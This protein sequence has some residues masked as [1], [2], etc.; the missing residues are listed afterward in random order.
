[1]DSPA[2]NFW[3][4][5]DQARRRYEAAGYVVSV[6]ERLESDV[7]PE[8]DTELVAY[9][10][11]RRGEDDAFESRII[12]LAPS[13]RDENSE[14]R[15]AALQ[16]FVDGRPGW[17]LDIVEFERPADARPPSQ[18]LVA[19]WIAEARRLAPLSPA[20]ALA[21][22]RR[23]V[24][25]ALFRLE[26]AR[27]E[28]YRE[29]PDLSNSLISGLE[30][31]GGIS[32]EEAETLR[33]FHTA[34]A[35]GDVS[36]DDGLALEE[37]TEACL[38]IAERCSAEDAEVVAE[39]LAW[40]ERHFC[41]PEQAGVAA[42]SSTG[43][44]VWLDTGPYDARAV[45]RSRFGESEQASLDRAVFLIEQDGLTWARRDSDGLPPTALA[46]DAVVMAT[47]PDAAAGAARFGV[48]IGAAPGYDGLGLVER[49]HILQWASTLPSRAEVVEL[50]RD[51]I[52]ETTPAH[53][54]IRI[55]CPTAEGTGRPDFDVVVE[56]RQ[57][58]TW[59]PAGRSGW[60]VSTS[61]DVARNANTNYRNRSSEA[62][63]DANEITYVYLTPRAWPETKAT[64]STT[65]D[66]AG[67]QPSRQQAKRRWQQ[68][69]SDEGHWRDVRALDV[70][71]L[72][73]WLIQAPATRARFSERL[74]LVPDGFT[75]AR[76][77]W[78]RDLAQTGGRL[79]AEVLLAGRERQFR[80][81]VE[82]CSTGGGTVYVVAES[83]QDALDFILAAGTREAGI[84]DRML[85]V[86]DAAAWRRLKREPGGG[87]ILVAVEPEVADGLE[88][89]QH[90]MVVPLTH[91]IPP[92]TS[93]DEHEALVEIGRI[94]PTAAANALE[95]QGLDRSEAGRFAALGRRSLGALRRMLQLGPTPATPAWL[96]RL[97]NDRDRAAVWA[98]LLAGRWSE[99][100]DSD[101]ALLC[102]LAGT[103]AGYEELLLI[104]R[105]L[106]EGPDPLIAQ[107]G[108]QWELVA[109][110][111]AWRHL[112]S[113]IPESFLD[114]FASAAERALTETEVQRWPDGTPFE[115][116]ERTQTRSSYS[117]DM[118][119][120]IARTAA[121]LGTFG[122]GAP[123]ASRTSA[124]TRAALM[125]R[126][127]LGTDDGG[128]H[129]LDQEAQASDGAPG[130]VECAVRS[131]IQRIVDLAGV[132]PLLAEAAPDAFLEAVADALEQAQSDPDGW[133]ILNEG[134]EG[135]TS[136]AGWY[137]LRR[138][139]ETLAWSPEPS[140]LAFVAES[141][142]KISASGNDDLAD[143]AHNCLVSLFRPW[144]PQTGLT[145][146]R[147][148]EVLTGLCNRVLGDEAFDA[149]TR[150]AALWRC[151][152]ELASLQPGGSPNAG[153]GIRE[154][155]VVVRPAS[156]EDELAATDR[157]ISLLLQMAEFFASSEF[158]CERL[159]DIFCPLD[160]NA[161]LVR[162][163]PG[164]RER[165]LE[166]V[167]DASAHGTLDASLL[168]D[169]MRSFVRLHRHYPDAF[170][171]LGSDELER[172]EHMADRWGDS[173]P[174]TLGAWLFESV[175]PEVD[176][177]GL[178]DEA[179][180]REA[181]VAAQRRAA[182]AQVWADDA[183]EGVLRLAVRVHDNSQ[184]F[185]WRDSASLKPLVP[186]VGRALAE[187]A[188]ARE[189]QWS[190]ANGALLEHLETTLGE[191]LAGAELQ[192]SADVAQSAD[193]DGESAL[194]SD[195]VVPRYLVAHGYFARRVALL[196][197]DGQNLTAWLK[198]IT[199]AHRVDSEAVARLLTTL[200]E[201]PLVWEISASLGAD[202]EAAYWMYFPPLPTGLDSALTV[203]AARRLLGVG[204]PGAAVEL[205]A[206]RHF[207]AGDSEEAA[208]GDN[209]EMV[210]LALRALEVLAD[211]AEPS[212]VVQRLRFW[213]GE[214]LDW[215]SH[216]LPLNELH[217]DDSRRIRLARL[218]L[219]LDD[220]PGSR[221][222][223][224]L[225]HAW[226]E[227]DP[228][229]FVEMIARM[230]APADE[231]MPSGPDE[232]AEADTAGALAAVAASKA[233]TVLHH[234][235]RIPGLRDDGTVDSGVMQDW[236]TQALE[237][238]AKQELLPLGSGYI[239]E[240][241][242][243][244]PAASSDE[245]GIVPPPAVRDVLEAL[246]S[247]GIEPRTSDIEHGLARGISN[248]RGVHSRG[249]MDGGKDERELADR[250]REQ[251]DIVGD[252]WP[253]TA[254][255]LRLVADSYDSHG[256]MHD[257]QSE[258]FARGT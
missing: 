234:W 39:M 147:R 192:T 160:G 236:I 116:H 200:R 76:L 100:R 246:R 94:D 106:S 96:G 149:S 7:G 11:A 189:L 237:E 180:A 164:A 169:R 225:S 74:G 114:R 101:Q 136:D 63:S 176:V 22:A 103:A 255:V 89:S 226:L 258:R 146:D 56:T 138:A 6:S 228:C 139:L 99:Q 93:S 230:Y 214:L 44:Y 220:V 206:Y 191:W 227:H 229:F 92:N 184:D 49:H 78:E 253:R 145:T 247:S 157:V 75:S 34:L 83:T 213:V 4:A 21:L 201:F 198:G 14:A 178:R 133:R 193:P 50:V 77:R 113:E 17:H 188:L 82:R 154:W 173:D 124:E 129:E 232:G 52:V 10:V 37:L 240:M 109:P 249:L 172:I 19:E 250:Y 88:P 9:F 41:T 119:H 46:A 183:L 150:R 36:R 97:P 24:A 102:E 207:E 51:L 174:A 85:L 144:L 127:L 90:C 167:G 33:Y 104:L 71:D 162:L 152:L 248:L 1:M 175:W 219:V 148:N 73:N 81:L 233:W 204:R 117:R 171:S 166:I 141:L 68:Q 65:S 2:L 170:W 203:V 202:V 242:A 128:G 80:E 95:R 185:P 16:A 26:V 122:I 20:G 115:I 163:T 187:A 158:E 155:P 123:L 87:A 43:D 118:R 108:N 210:E 40:F 194:G 8:P 98:A 64:P 12:E 126:D 182:V 254:R 221:G 3:A 53:D 251:A 67:T 216:Q 31:D 120:G 121:L 42:D 29:P 209:S 211:A 238:L 208:S 218:E 223:S 62:R 30:T 35:A 60:E 244:A 57:G 66:T 55:D 130:Q 91:P 86:S 59:V 48:S 257:I 239:G 107:V 222:R 131:V 27:G 134:S 72:L 212:Q 252:R 168:G 151:L 217:L 186:F 143:K 231:S 159:S 140:H 15:L 61:T 23:A 142:L 156:H 70:D 25:S 111:E 179:G 84:L 58:T 235:R 197:D 165:A 215:L 45:L 196:L 243:K 79:S 153:P 195:A 13:D 28:R 161:H 38:R 137:W 245:H 18:D 190:G 32:V 256:R 5:G 135:A 132:L 110:Q 205:L 105:P 181:L 224:L 112:A 177:A 125:V 47:N 69:H 199:M 241:L 54:L